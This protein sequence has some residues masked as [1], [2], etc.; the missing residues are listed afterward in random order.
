MWLILSHTKAS[1]PCLPELVSKIRRRKIFS[2][3]GTMK[4]EKRPKAGWNVIWQS[5]HGDIVLLL[6]Y[7]FSSSECDSFSRSC[8]LARQRPPLGAIFC[9]RAHHWLAQV[10][11]GHSGLDGFCLALFHNSVAKGNIEL[12]CIPLHLLSK[13]WD[14]TLASP[15]LVHFLF[16][17]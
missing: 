5:R 15:C 6:P 8:P 1:H 2:A 13:C 10:F 4:A 7:C 9:S 11:S 14:Y 3:S 17:K 12:I 16:S